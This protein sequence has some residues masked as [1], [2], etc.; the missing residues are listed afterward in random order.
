[1][2]CE[3]FV[4]QTVFARRWTEAFRLY[5][6]GSAI[7]ALTAGE[8]LRVKCLNVDDDVFYLFFQKQKRTIVGPISA[9]TGGCGA[10]VD[11]AVL[12]GPAAQNITTHE[13]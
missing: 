6:L 1:V 7:A 9:D 10:G 5:E 11:G 12:Y 13:A 3:D 8:S 4:W 2:L